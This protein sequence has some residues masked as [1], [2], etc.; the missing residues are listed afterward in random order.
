MSDAVITLWFF[1]LEAIFCNLAFSRGFLLR[2]FKIALMG[3]EC[4]HLSVFTIWN[5]YHSWRFRYFVFARSVLDMSQCLS[6]NMSTSEEK[7]EC[8]KNKEMKKALKTAATLLRV[9][10][11]RRHGWNM[12]CCL[13]TCHRFYLR[14]V[15]MILNKWFFRFKK[16]I[17]ESFYSK[18]NLS[19]T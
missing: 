15:L 13:H 7:T 6:I 17:K 1:C 10:Q 8:L 18:A 3:L 11:W 4:P 12:R 19:Y 16:S 14:R 2:L 5:E 9:L